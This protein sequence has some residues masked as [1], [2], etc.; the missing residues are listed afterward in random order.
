MNDSLTSMSELEDIV[1][2]N[3]S[4]EERSDKSPLSILS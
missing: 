4:D 2:L 3:V 1:V